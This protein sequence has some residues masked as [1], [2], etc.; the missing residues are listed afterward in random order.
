MYQTTLQFGKP[1]ICCAF[2]GG[3]SER[4][5]DTQIDDRGGEIRFARD[6]PEACRFLEDALR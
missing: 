6:V 1:I 4:F 3:W 2:A 5:A